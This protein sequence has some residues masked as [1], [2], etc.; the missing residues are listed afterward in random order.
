MTSTASRSEITLRGSTAIVTE[1]FGYAV[2]SILYQRGLYRAFFT[3]TFYKTPSKVK[4]TPT[5]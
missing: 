5:K 1:F 4:L 2:N 3:F